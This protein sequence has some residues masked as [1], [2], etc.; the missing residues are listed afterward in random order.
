ML[1]RRLA[2]PLLASAFLADGADT[3]M[4]PDERVKAANTLLEQQ[5]ESRFAGV[6]EKLPADPATLVKINAGAQI[7]GGVLL[8]TGKVPRLASLMLAMTV[9]PSAVT[10]QDFWQ[11]TDP[12]RKAAKR[13][14]F[15]KDMSLLGG[16]LIA[17]ADTEGRPSL[18]W[19]G[20]RAA[21]RTAAAVS[22]ALPL[23]A[24]DHAGPAVR[25]RLHDT[26]VRARHVAEVA[27]SKGAEV[28]GTAKE[29]SQE[30]AEVARERGP[31]W[32]ETARERGTEIAEIAR[33]RGS[34]LAEIA[35]ERGPELAE[36]ARERGSHLAEIARE[37]GPEYAGAARERSAHLAE[38]AR[39][40]G[41][42]WA[43][44]AR[45]RSAHLA[46]LARQRGPEVADAAK[47]RGAEWTARTRRRGER[48]AGSARGRTTS[49]RR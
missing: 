29:R 41:P 23:G 36:A 15:F 21:Q 20:R 17:S 47:G 37:R 31:E 13:T 44:T 38:V 33:E 40:R 30:L 35:R 1:L 11:E 5:R 16:L 25:D 19:R 8:A 18:G 2:R 49:R 12:T 6:A 10:N 28:A 26:A 48:I 45:E 9:V 42:E 43:E 22:A 7:A 39:E 3:L 24:S 14:A 27:A 4:H 32:A 46:E 34:H